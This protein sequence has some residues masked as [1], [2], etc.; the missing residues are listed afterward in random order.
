MKLPL[1][2]LVLISAMPISVLPTALLQDRMQHLLSAYLAHPAVK[3]GANPFSLVMGPARVV[4]AFLLHFDGDVERSNTGLERYHA[5]FSHFQQQQ[6]MQHSPYHAYPYSSQESSSSAQQYQQRDRERSS[7]IES[8]TYS[9]AP[10]TPGGGH[11]HRYGSSRDYGGSVHIHHA[12]SAAGRTVKPLLHTRII[13]VPP[14][15]SLSD[16][17]VVRLANEEDDLQVGCL[18]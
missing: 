4:E 6:M 17:F 14:A 1:R 18:F 12:S 11:G 7:S 5:Q 13:S 9:P 10:T 15:I 16:G 3:G 2:P 8:S